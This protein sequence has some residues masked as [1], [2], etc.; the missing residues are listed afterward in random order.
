[1]YLNILIQTAVQV[2]LQCHEQAL[3]TTDSQ[4]YNLIIKD[5]IGKKQSGKLNVTEE[6]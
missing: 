4:R 2:R 5:D 1:M 6:K 3:T